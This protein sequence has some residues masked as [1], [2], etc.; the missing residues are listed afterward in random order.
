MVLF[1]EV[2][3]ETKGLYTQATSVSQIIRGTNM[4]SHV[5]AVPRVHT[6]RTV[7]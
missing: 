6:I 7:A 2:N 5:D 3:V 4:A 1:A